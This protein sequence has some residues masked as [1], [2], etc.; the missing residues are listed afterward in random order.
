MTSMRKK[1]LWGGAVL[2]LLALAIPKVLS[3]QKSPGRNTGGGGG[4]G[5]LTVSSVVVLPRPLEE[6]VRAIGTLSANEEVELRSERSGKIQKIYF[7][8]G[9][10]V[11]AGDVLVKI[12]D[13]ELSAQL[14]RAEQRRKLAEQLEERQKVLLEKGGVS[15]E[16]YDRILTEL[17]TLRAEEQLIRVQVEKTEI[18]APFDGIIGLRYASEG[19]Y[20]TSADRLATLQDLGS[21]KIDFSIPEKYAR[22]VKPGD[23]IVFTTAGAERKFSGTV[24]AVEPKVDP[25]TRTLPV[26]ARASNVN[27]ALVPGGFANVELVLRQEQALMVPAGA[28]IPDIRG[29]KV[30]LYKG[31]K[32]E[33]RE[34]QVG[35]RTADEVEIAAGISPGDTVLTSGLLQLRPGAAVRLSGEAAN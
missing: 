4:G 20:V 18:Q 15:R 27:R 17:N 12:D 8:E 5:E 2:L 10:A 31:G 23:K 13:S 9:G 25:A 21:L 14:A 35:L 30:F 7:R 34:V 32:A 24:F 29:H 3:L 33:A 22:Q 6:T 28:V 26:R 1:W 19:S 16:E 11:K